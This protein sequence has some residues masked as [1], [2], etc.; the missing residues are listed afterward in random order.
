MLQQLL[1]YGDSASKV[2]ILL[3]IELF[4][5]RAISGS[6]KSH[7][8][9]LHPHSFLSISPGRPPLATMVS[10]FFMSASGNSVVVGTS[11]TL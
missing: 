7:P 9:E 2:G 1:V 11:L 5:T 4:Y 6:A 10:D 8:N 3:S